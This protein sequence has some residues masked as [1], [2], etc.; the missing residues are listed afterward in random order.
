MHKPGRKQGRYPEV[1]AN[2]GGKPET[3]VRFTTVRPPLST[4]YR[5]PSRSGLCTVVAVTTHV[6]GA[7]GYVSNGNRALLIQPA[8]LYILPNEARR[9]ISFHPH[10]HGRSTPAV[11]ARE[12]TREPNADTGAAARRGL[13]PDSNGLQIAD[14]DLDTAW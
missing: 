12:T 11:G 3:S 5:P 9:Y 6:T 13:R 10:H 1:M 2:G 14:S 4:R 7:R 8:D